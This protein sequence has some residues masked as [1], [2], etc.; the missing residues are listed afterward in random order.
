MKIIEQVNKDPSLIKR[1]SYEELESLSEEISQIIIDTV[2][3]N[4]GH[5]SSNLGIIELTVSLHKVF[6]IPP[7]KIIWDVGHQCYTHKLLTQR[8]SSFHSLRK[9]NGISGY[10]AP[11]ESLTD[12]FHTGHAGTAV[13]SATGLKTGQLLLG[14]Q[15]KVIAVIG[16]GSLTNGV[17]FEGLNFLGTLS[18]N[19]LIILNDNKMS[20]SPTK[21][22]LSYYL[23]KLITSPIINR[24]KK[25]FAEVLQSIPSIG[26]DI[27][28]VAQEVEKKTKHLF[29]PG[30]LFE[31]MGLKYFGPIDGHDIRQLTDILANIKDI[32][33]PVLLHV[34]TKKGKGY[35]PAEEKPADFHSAGP[36]DKKTGNF[37]KKHH[38]SSGAIA[39]Q[40]LE[41]LATE[42]ENLIVLTAAMV[43][44]L[45]LEGFATLF[46]DKFYDVGISESHC[47]VYASGLAKAGMKVVV[48]IYSTFLQRG[49]DQIF[50]DICLQNLPVIFLIDRAGL[51]GE[52]GPTH[53]GIFD[54]SFLRSLPNLKIVAP[55]SISNLKETIIASFKEN[56]PIFIRFPKGLLPENITPLEETS[57]D[58]IILGCGSMAEN[59][60][61]ACQTLQKK[62]VKISFLPIDVIKPVNK[63]VIEKINKYATIITVEENSI[64]G[65]FGSSICEYIS[66]K[67]LNKKLLRIGLPNAFIEQGKRNDLLD[68]YG[69]SSIKIVEKI[70]EFIK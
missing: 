33:E 61:E 42:E 59:A 17:T 31:K 9:E 63:N 26:K 47:I 69:L 37:I 8:Y 13:S 25:E 28:R 49:Y 40:L 51:V 44:G 32:E 15:S 6:D 35:Q 64:E 5:L 24:P 70:E 21:G 23:A 57:N 11:V 68:K 66:D 36:F 3:V 62:G 34:V 14:N 27:I 54:I 43:K 29:I 4:G 56:M 46:P 30:V 7:D 60:F 67:G 19:P 12:I 48:A 20:I 2:A 10:P 22:A 52:D 45:G 53:H 39:G 65:G 38:R 58:K 16:D 41:Q 55:Y 50:Q 1:L 18:K